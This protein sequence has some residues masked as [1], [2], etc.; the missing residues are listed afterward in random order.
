MNSSQI[1]KIF[2]LPLIIAALL[3]GACQKDEEPEEKGAN[4]TMAAKEA[5]PGD[6]QS[7]EDK[8]GRIPPLDKSKIDKSPKI[9][10]N[11]S[12][13]C[14]RLDSTRYALTDSPIA[15]ESLACWKN[16]YETFGLCVCN[17]EFKNKYNIPE[18]AKAI[19]SFID[20]TVKIMN[21]DAALQGYCALYK[22]EKWTKDDV[23]YM[24]KLVNATKQCRLTID[25]VNALFNECPIIAGHAEKNAPWKKK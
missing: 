4:K 8:K 14:F 13:A 24:I 2:S 1:L 21:Y 17:N 25:C 12:E 3:T 23:I 18:E 7:D 11:P 9:Q 15:Q 20:N 22:A 10:Y 16:Q 19:R 5:K 6:A